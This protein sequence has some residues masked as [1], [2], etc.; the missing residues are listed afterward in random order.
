MSGE[1]EG[2]TSSSHESSKRPKLQ[3]AC[4]LCR[5]KKIR[6]DGMDMPDNRCS[7]CAAYG[8]E[9]TY[10][11]IN[12]RPPAKTYVDVLE[13]RLQKMEQLVDRLQPQGRSPS[14][15]SRSHSDL[16]DSTSPASHA[17]QSGPA[18]PLPPPAFSVPSPAESNDLDPSDDEAETQRE[19]VDFLRLFSLPPTLSIRYHG[20]SSSM[21]LLQAAMDM[22]RQYTGIDT[23]EYITGFKGS[24]S[25]RIHATWSQAFSGEDV[26]P[27]TDFPPPEDMKLLIDLYFVNMNYFLPVLHRQSFERHIEE[28]LHLRSPA[29]GSVVLLV[30]AN[31]C[32]WTDDP[33]VAEYGLPDIPGWKLFQQVE[34]ARTS[35]FLPPRLHDVQKY[36]LMAEYLG[37]FISPHNCWA[38]VG[39]G[40][41]TIQDVGAHRQKTYATKDKIEAEQWKRAFWVLIVYDRMVSFNL[42]RPCALQDEDFDVEPVVE[43]DDEY[44]DL[45][46]KESPFKQP[47]GKPS[48]IA[49]LNCLNRLL[50]I[51]AFASR[52]I[53]SINKSKIL[54]GFIGPEWEERIVAEL[55]SLLNKWI[56]TVPDHLRW[57]PH[58]EDIGFLQQSTLLYSHYY[59]LQ[60]CVHRP[61]LP[62]M[63][64]TSRLS[65]PSLAICTNAARCCVHINEVQTKRSGMP[66]TFSRVPLSIAGVVLLLNMWG[67]KRSG[68]S[69]SSA[70]ADVQKCLSMLKHLEAK[71]H[72]AGRLIY[73]LTALYSAGDFDA[74]EATNNLKRARDSDVTQST[75]SS[76]GA[77]GSPPQKQTPP[78]STQGKQQVPPQQ[79]SQ[80]VPSASTPS[81]AE[82]TSTGSWTDPSIDS[83]PDTVNLPMSTE[84][85]GRVP[86][87]YGFSPFFDPALVQKQQQPHTMPPQMQGHVADP[88]FMQVPGQTAWGGAMQDPGGYQAGA[89]GAGPSSYQNGAGPSTFGGMFAPMQ[90]MQT[91]N[92]QGAYSQYPPPQSS[93][94][95]QQTQDIGAASDMSGFTETDLAL[96]DNTLEMWSTAPTSLDWGDWGSFLNSVSGGTSSEWLMSDGPG[97]AF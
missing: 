93:A 53:Y 52:T 96:A 68:L 77:G 2:S 83:S 56:D 41:R 47:P 9:C 50:Q 65:L 95:P 35:L 85:L 37:S 6:C 36:A 4:D 79:S 31:G 66:L 59:Q 27:Y 16:T 84:D 88:N 26:P 89:F 28:G 81:L 69:N 87:N 55:D 58:R 20:K 1:K 33:G 23:R 70:A 64:K 78:T 17:P 82:G 49:M 46:D 18:S 67:G 14:R 13:S 60:I 25:E 44:W 43:C 12:R 91:P 19:L 3:R 8:V 92:G 24:A 42:G 72:T 76:S 94:T 38:L 32:R 11:V 39:L 97:S 22:K 75:S 54:M 15:E 51:L 40:L 57:D 45:G 63:R 80:A 30:C 21:M 73:V 10:D 34:K 90:G 71:S 5:K 86:F 62:A 74:S 7:K 29:F 61:F 48:Y